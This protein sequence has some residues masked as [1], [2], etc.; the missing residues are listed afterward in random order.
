M[1]VPLSKIEVDMANSYSS[2]HAKKLELMAQRKRVLDWELFIKFL[3]SVEIPKIKKYFKKSY[4][5]N[6]RCCYF[7]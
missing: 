5:C 6:Y 7:T 4:T 2:S 3:F 1:S